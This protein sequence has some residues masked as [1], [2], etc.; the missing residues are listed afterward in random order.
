MAERERER[1][2]ERETHSVIVNIPLKN[3]D[4]AHQ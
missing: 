3:I 2:R 4:T 1:E